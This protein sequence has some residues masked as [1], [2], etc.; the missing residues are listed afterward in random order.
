MLID[1]HT[2]LDDARYESDREAM[3][4]LSLIH[5]SLDASVKFTVVKLRNESGRPR[6]LSATGYVEWALGDLR[7]KSVMHVISEIDPATGALFARNAYNTDFPGRIAFFDVDEG[8]R[9]MTGDRTE[10]LGRNG[11]L[12][13]PA[14]MSR[15]RLS[16][17]VGAA[18]DPCGAIQ[19]PFDLAVG[20]ERDCTFRLGV[21]KDTEDARQLVRRFRGATARLSLIHI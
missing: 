10:F 20:Q 1:T 3:I 2:H 12:R 8:T 4:A 21:G 11:T 16:G 7:P 13:N 19:L 14:S 5:I 18:L 15:S 6:R 17:K 9:S